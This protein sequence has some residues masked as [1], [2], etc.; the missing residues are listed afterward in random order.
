MNAPVP[1]PT[2]MTSFAESDTWRR[3]VDAFHAAY[4]DALDA[5]RLADWPAF[6]TEDCFYRITA[7]E[8]RDLG[9]PVGLVYCE[10][11]AMLRD[12]AFAIEKTAMHAPRYLR[13]FITNVRID[14]IDEG[15]TVIH[16]RANYLLFQVLMDRPNATLHQMGEYHDVFRVEGDSLLLASRDCVYDNALI[17]NA[18]VYPV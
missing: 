8:N 14:S 9:L 1:F 2:A 3:R 12:R 6:F 7:R 16:A 5:G 15:G 4:C 13:H 10:G 17:D 18:L 11:R